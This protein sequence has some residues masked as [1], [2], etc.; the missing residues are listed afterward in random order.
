MTF[1]AAVQRRLT[2]FVFL[3]VP[4]TF[5]VVLNIYPVLQL[6]WISLTDF[7][8]INWRRAEFVGLRNFIDLFTFDRDLLVPMTRSLYYLG[9]SVVQL[10]L[11]TWFAVVLNQKLPGSRMFRTILFIPFVLN[12]VAAGLIFKNF[13]ELNGAANDILQ[14]FFGEDFKVTWLDS[15]KP[16]SNLS[17]AAASVW[18]YLGFNLVVTFGALQAIPQDQYD[19]A[20]LEGANQ[21]QQFWRITFPSIRLV[22]LLQFMLSLVGSLEVFEVPML[23]TRGAGE[24]STFAITMIETGFQNRRAGTAAAMAVLMLAVVVIVFIITR[25]ISSSRTAMKEPL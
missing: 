18:R 13:L 15:S 24:T 11:A 17:L 9:G 2:I 21:W 10:F 16:Y 14:L 8:S 20:R 12:A 5:L 23:I 1:N 19:A 6:F 3:L 7:N 25:L 4:V 22:L